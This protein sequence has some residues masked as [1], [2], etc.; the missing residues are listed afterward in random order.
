[1]QLDFGH[2]WWKGKSES[3]RNIHLHLHM[4]RWKW[5][6]TEPFP[7]PHAKQ[8]GAAI[9]VNRRPQKLSYII[10][11]F[12]WEALED[13][14][15]FSFLFCQNWDWSLKHTFCVLHFTNW[16][17]LFSTK[18]GGGQDREKPG[19]CAKA[20]SCNRQLTQN[21]K[22]R[23]CLKSKDFNTNKLVFDIWKTL[24]FIAR[25]FFK[26]ALLLARWDLFPVICA[27]NNFAQD[28]DETKD[29]NMFHSDQMIA[30]ASTNSVQERR[31]ELRWKKRRLF[32][33][34]RIKKQRRHWNCESLGVLTR[35][36]TCEVIW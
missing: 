28:D 22:V 15:V 19:C 4:K 29:F 16:L 3:E 2:K 5:K 25:R 14:Q 35:F 8:G 11:E 10:E 9:K 24:F 30:E 27:S 17:M 6:W 32:R 7:S 33:G 36:S 26:G 13:F 1:M 31:W 18:I 23:N 34:A 20:R 12:M 21:A